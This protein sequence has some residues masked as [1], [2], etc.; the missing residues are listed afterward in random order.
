M[1]ACHT[2]KRD[3]KKLGR[4]EARNPTLFDE[5]SKTD[6]FLNIRYVTKVTD[7]I[8]LQENIVIQEAPTENFKVQTDDG[9]VST[10]VTRYHRDTIIEYK[11]LT[12][13]LPDT[14]TIETRDTTIITEVQKEVITKVK[15]E[16]PV[17]MWIASGGLLVLVLFSFFR[18]KN[19]NV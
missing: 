2:T 13:S 5:Y 6:T 3:A 10:D 14:V 19:H 8:I 18:R 11:V 1:L 9:K 7:T 12:V 17:W 4:I 16:I 15:K